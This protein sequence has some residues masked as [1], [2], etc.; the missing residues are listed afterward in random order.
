MGY[1]EAT[2]VRLVSLKEGRR[3]RDEER[4]TRASRQAA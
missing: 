3:Q 4:E 1:S 2:A